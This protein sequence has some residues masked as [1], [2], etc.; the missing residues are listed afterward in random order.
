M[1]LYDPMRGYLKEKKIKDVMELMDKSA[2]YVHYNSKRELYNKNLRCY[3]LRE[4]PSIQK[5]RKLMEAIHFDEETWKDIPGFD[6][7]Q[8][9]NVGRVRNKNTKKILLPIKVKTFLIVNVKENNKPYKICAVA[10]LVWLAFRGQ[11]PKNKF[12]AHI[13][14]DEMDNN[15]NNL[16][17]STLQE[18]IRKR[19]ISKR[20]VAKIEPNGE[21]TEYPS[22]NDAAADNYIDRSAIT[23][24]LAGKSKT[25]AG[26]KWIYL[27]K[28]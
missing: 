17:L 5:R 25:A 23:K 2:A 13:G 10:R 15:I 16:A 7:Y 11:I 19:G 1:W 9:S 4:K 24:A 14:V 28:S 18:R 3:L 27:E 22:L 20:P 6:N 21:I 8:A 12:V 26:C